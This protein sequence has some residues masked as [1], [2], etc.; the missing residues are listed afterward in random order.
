[1]RRE[2]DP[3]GGTH[4][5]YR[6]HLV[7]EGLDAELVGSE[8]AV[9]RLPD[10][11][12]AGIGGRQ[13]GSVVVSGCPSLTAAAAVDAVG[14]RLLRK[15][16]HE[17]GCE[18]GERDATRAK[19]LA[20]TKLKL[21]QI[22]G[23]FR[24][25]YF[26]FPADA[27]G[28]PYAA[29][30]DAE[31]GRILALQGANPGASCAPTEPLRPVTA[32]GIPVRPELTNWRGLKANVASRAE[33]P[34]HEGVFIPSDGLIRHLVYQRVTSDNSTFRC[35]S[36]KYYTLFPLKIDPALNC[37]SPVYDDVARSGLYP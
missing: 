16:E 32:Y 23:A 19:R 20:Q 34:T 37:C 7:G 29:V 18:P 5:F 11:R 8:I 26:T 22:D 28:E 6:Q 25:A 36:T 30:V 27:E 17:P 2:A 4:I 31:N 35:G 1:M 3:D 14:E 12:L 15:E 13:F 10:G 24:P 21:V 9:H 33:G